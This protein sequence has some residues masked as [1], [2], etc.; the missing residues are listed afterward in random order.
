MRLWLAMQCYYSTVATESH[1]VDEL[2]SMMIYMVAIW[3][4]I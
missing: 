1:F 3:T 2:V 4:V